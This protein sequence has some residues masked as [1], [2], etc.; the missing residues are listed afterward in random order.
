MF[1]WL[2][3]NDCSVNHTGALTWLL[4]NTPYKY[5]KAV[6]GSGKGPISPNTGEARKLEC[7]RPPTQ[8]P[9]ERRQ[10]V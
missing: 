9:R 4:R 3:V 2:L 5:V 8:K 7:D 1:H 6:D 10:P